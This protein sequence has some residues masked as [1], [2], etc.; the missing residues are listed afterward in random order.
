MVNIVNI[1]KIV[2]PL[3]F[4]LTLGASWTAHGE[5]VSIMTFNVENLFDN[6]DDPG[7]DETYLP[8]ETK[9]TNFISE[10][11][12]SEGA[13][14]ARDLFW[15]WSDDVVRQKLKVVGATIRQ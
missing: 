5:A 8:K 6:T 3:L 7:R 1:V 15:D 2:I 9:L 4:L 14:L 11:P 10:M 12:P 13:S